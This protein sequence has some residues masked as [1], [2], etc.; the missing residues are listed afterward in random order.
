MFIKLFLFLIY[1][2]S[3]I[4]GFVFPPGMEEHVR[5]HDVVVFL[6][7]KGLPIPPPTSSPIPSTLPPPFPPPFPPPSPPPP[8]VSSK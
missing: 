3:L 6:V 1:S 4:D 2:S 8:Q 5:A 7:L